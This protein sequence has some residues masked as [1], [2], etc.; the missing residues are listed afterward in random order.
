[1]LL[2]HVGEISRVIRIRKFVIPRPEKDNFTFCLRAGNKF[3]ITIPRSISTYMC[4]YLFRHLRLV[5]LKVKCAE[6][7]I[8]FVSQRKLLRLEDCPEEVL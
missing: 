8:V 6:M 3:K 1:M 7:V 2:A 5:R 4:V